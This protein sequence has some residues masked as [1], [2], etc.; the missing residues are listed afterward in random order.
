M[1]NP[2]PSSTGEIEDRSQDIVVVSIAMMVPM[3]SVV[4]LRFWVRWRMGGG[5]GWDDWCI[6]IA[7]VLS[8]GMSAF[9]ILSAAYGGGKHMRD[10]PPMDIPI[11]LKYNF[12]SQV[13]S[14]PA[15][16]MVKISAGLFLLRLAATNVYRNICI[17]F[18][19]LMTLYSVAST[20]TI[21]FQCVPVQSIWD[22]TVKGAKCLSPLVRINLGKSYSINCAISDCFLVLL[23]IAMLWDVQIARRK[24]IAICSILGVGSLAAAASIVKTTYLHSYGKTGDFL[25][26][27]VNIAVWTTIENDVAIISA[28]MP[29]LKPLFSKILEKTVYS[30]SSRTG[31]SQGHSL[32]ALGQ[33]S[34]VVGITNDIRAGR[35]RNSKRGTKL[36]N[37]SEEGIIGISKSTDVRVDVETVS[38]SSV[39]VGNGQG[40]MGAR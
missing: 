10:I 18:I 11:G 21:I 29:A 12:L 39:E 7:M 23:P 38:N 24:R 22:P 27:S 31:G 17:G 6:G 36:D 26:D 5:L 4:F 15:M 33:N 20:F 40:C 9:V 19:V 2:T 37:E 28:S 8:M 13:F 25:W 3:V 32:S 1:T 30:Y 14:L 34:K 16:M 35:D